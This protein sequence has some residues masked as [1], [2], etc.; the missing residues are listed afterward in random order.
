MMQ[1]IPLDRIAAV[2]R[3]SRFYTRR[4]GAL[5]E[6]LSQSRF[7]LTA[8]RVLYE[9]ANRACPTAREIGAALDLDAGYLSRILQGFER[10]GLLTRAPTKSDRRQNVLAL[11]DAGRA[12]FVPLDRAA[13]EEVAALLT[14]LPDFGQADLVAAM[15]RIELLLGETASSAWSLR[16]PSAGDIGWVVE[17][18][19]ALYAAEYGFDARFEALVARVAAEFLAQND[20]ARERC[21]IVMRGGVRVGSIFVVRKSDETAKLRLLLVEPEARG[22]GIGKALVAACIDFARAAGYRSMT[23]WTNDVLVAAR[24]IYQAAGFKLVSST[25]HRD[26]GPAIVGEDWELMI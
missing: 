22:L 3:F 20:P 6:G 26:F 1:P 21:W 8:A 18:H 5:R 24:G 4:I 23:L 17:R 2:R 25:P 14:R 9:L 15:T 13:R 19:G 7:S 11:T 10:E 16:P 12:A